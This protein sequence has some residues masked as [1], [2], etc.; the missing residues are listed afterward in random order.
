MSERT[1]PV[2]VGV[3][4]SE[5]ATKAAVWAAAVA[6]KFHAPLHIVHAI[7]DTGRLLTDAAAAMLA[8]L[9]AEQR[10]SADA[11]L[12]S[13]EEAVRTR[14]GKLT[15]TAERSDQSASKVLTDLSGK[16]RLV[17]L[18]SKEVSPSAALLLGSTTVAV[19]AHS[20]CPVV[21][22]RGE[23]TAPTD[24]P[25]VL[26]V[27]PERTGAAAFRTAFEFADRFGVPVH[28]VNAWPGRRTLGGIEIPALV[29]WGAV[30]AAQW[31]Y[32]MGAVEP[33]SEKYPSVEV[34][35]FVE[36]AGAGAALLS[37]AP[38]AQLV[39]VGSR[40][41]GLLAGALLGST[42]LN[43]LQHGPVPVLVCHNANP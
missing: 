40:G 14:F 23:I 8:S 11:T 15:V 4:G 33:W 29:D 25:V 17:V 31:Q 34:R 26:G 37:H 19:T 30:E 43:M 27:E 41:R 39:V 7:A 10:K 2:V 13:V 42:S 36:T 21:T 3:D 38:D 24:Q 32:V 35:Y 9:I 22:W 20:S 16:A 28:A 12:K 1:G 18:G 6:E 5:E